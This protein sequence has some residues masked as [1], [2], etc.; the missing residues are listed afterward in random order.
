MSFT[1]RII[2]I[3]ICFFQPL[4]SFD[5]SFKKI[6]AW[7]SGTKEETFFQEFPIAYNATVLLENSNGNINVKSWSLPKIAI[8]AIKSGPPKELSKISIETIPLNNQL[9]IR[10]VLQ[11]K[12][13]YVHYKLIV[14][15]QLNLILK[16]ENGSIKIKKSSGIIQATTS[17]GSIDI[18]EASNSIYALASGPI[19]VGFSSI[20][21]QSTISLKS[22]KSTVALNLPNN[23]HATVKA[24]TMFNTIISHHFITLKPITTTFNKQ[25]WEH[26]KRQLQGTIGNGGA[27]ISIAAYNGIQFLE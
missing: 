1:L 23:T 18:Q 11:S 17:N 13:N 14:P 4:D 19:T 27:A 12:N 2:L 15:T 25:T 7:F 24:Q 9:S 6:T 10:T 20:P 16:T 3:C 26:F 8:E 5:F 21:L 22:L